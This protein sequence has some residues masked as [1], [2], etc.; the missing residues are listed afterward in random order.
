MKKISKLFLLPLIIIYFSSLFAFGQN[1][2][3]YKKKTKFPVLESIKEKRDKASE[4]AQKIT[5]IIIKKNKEIKKQKRENKKTLSSDMRGVF[6]PVSPKEFNRVFHFP[7]V[8]QFYTSTCWSFSATSYYESEIYR[9][10]KRK[11]KLSEMWT[12]YFELIEKAVRFINER[13]FSE[14]SGGA[15]SNSINRIW[16]KYGIV[17]A[18]AYTGILNK[19]GRHDHIP[20]MSELK[21]YFNFV[22]E[23][24][25]WNE[26][27]NIAHI[28]LILNKYMGTPPETFSYNGEKYNAKTFFKEIVNLN[29]DDYCSVMSTKYFPFYTK[30][31]FTVP[32]NW[33]HSKDYINLPLNI[34]YDIVRKSIKKG[35]SMVIGGDVSEPGKIGRAD[36]SFIPTFDIPAR[37]INQDSREFRIYNKTTQDDHGL[38]LVGYKRKI[39]NDWFLIKDSGRSGRLGK[40][41]GYYFFRDDFI[42]LKMLTFTV[43]KDMLK[44]ILPKIK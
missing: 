10:H 14:F 6:P 19:D 38:H 17:P 21:A 35:Y 26:K 42:K 30:Q 5:N 16:K 44:N 24:N 2:A 7:P 36:I 4:E 31:E 15:E 13:G 29:M 27:E 23:N 8:A 3:V 34:W 40:F 22:K 43:H 41:K 1:K 39:G 9:L 18:K 33:W 20:M 11:V 12:V 28:K 32:D 25:L 37:Y